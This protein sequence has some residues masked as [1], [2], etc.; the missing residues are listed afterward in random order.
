VENPA[1]TDRDLTAVARR[2]R[3]ADERRD[4]AM[5]ARDAAIVRA[6]AQGRTK[7]EVARLCGVTKMRVGQIVERKEG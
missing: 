5:A 6:V 2:F 3:L 1:V 4:K 7:A